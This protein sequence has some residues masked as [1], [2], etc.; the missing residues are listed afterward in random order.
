MSESQELEGVKQV[1]RSVV[2]HLDL[3]TTQISE[4]APLKNVSREWKTEE[5][6]ILQS[7]VASGNSLRQLADKVLGNTDQSGV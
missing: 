2:A 7:F 4:L 3:V 6:K 1:L 5:T